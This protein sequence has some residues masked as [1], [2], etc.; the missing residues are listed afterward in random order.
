MG[1]PDL[2]WLTWRSMGDDVARRECETLGRE[3]PHGL[4]FSELKKHAY[5]GW[6]HRIARFTRREAE[7]TVAFVLVPGRE[8][9]LGHDGRNFKP[10]SRQIE[11][12]RPWPEIWRRQG[13]H[14]SYIYR[15]IN[16]FIEANTSPPRTVRVP[17]ILLEV[18]AREIERRNDIEPLQEGD[19]RFE[20]YRAEYPKN[21]RVEYY[22]GV[23]GEDRHI[24]ERDGDGALR[25]WRRPPTTVQYIKERL[26]ESG[27]RL[28]TCDEWEHACGAGV[29][30]LFRW[31]DDNPPNF[32]PTDRVEEH[33]SR[34]A[35]NLLL[36]LPRREAAP[37]D[38][39][40]H[41][42]PNLFGLRIAS[43][44]YQRDLVA[45]EPWALGGDGGCYICGGTGSFL[46]W[47]PLATA[48]RDSYQQVSLRPD[49]SNV[50][51]E[52]HRLRRVI[53]VE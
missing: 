34:R 52:Y 13:A 26:A 50:A 24:V 51:N 7:G 17:T 38:W 1:M 14:P 16:D 12:Y 10:S 31:G 6:T 5:A 4:E 45:D 21:G 9:S 23:L 42:R 8:V 2:S 33:K 11:S 19:P 3:L 46:A 39:D 27:M 25:V 49:E 20:Q 29:S 35:Q 40:L 30:T 53:P 48:F 32:G 18:E 28:P 22:G 37:P 43:N 15:S 41:E 36:G 47:F 44:P